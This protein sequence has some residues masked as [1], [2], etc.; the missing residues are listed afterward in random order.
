MTSYEK[1]REL[2]NKLFQ[3]DQADLDFGIYRIM[4][5]KRDEISRFLDERLLPQV[6]EALGEYQATLADTGQAEL[7]EAIE[8]ARGLGV[9]PDEAPRVQEL[10][11]KH[12]EPQDIGK[13]EDEVYSHL[14]SFFRRYYSEG[15]FISQRRYKEGV[16]AIPYEGEEV[17]LHWANHDQYY[18]KSSENFRNYTFRLPDDRMVHFRI[19]EASTGRDNNRAQDDKHRRFMLRD[20]E[21]WGPADDIAPDPE[22][23][24]D[25]GPLALELGDGD[26]DVTDAPT[27]PVGYSGPAITVEDDDLVIRF[28]FLPDPQKRRQKT[29][30]EEIATAV[31]A[32]PA[33]ADWLAGLRT[34]QPTEANADRTLL[35]KHLDQYSKRN[36]FDYFIHKDLGGFLRRELDFYTKNEVMRLDDIENETAPR[37][38]QYLGKVRA[39]RRVAGKL[40]TFL[41]QL[42]DFQKKLW[43]KKKFV[44]ETNYCVT[45]DRVPEEMWP[46]V[47]ANQAQR[48]EWTR[49]FDVSADDERPE[50][51][52]PHLVVDTA[53]FPEAFTDRLLR[54]WDGMEEEAD[55]LLCHGDNFHALTLLRPTW[56]TRVQ[57]VYIDPP[58]NAD[59]TEIVYK[60]AYKHSSWLS[61]IWDR[62]IC[63][64]EML[65]ETGVMCVTIDDYEV[66]GLQYAL[67]RAFGDDNYLATT[68]IRNNP[69]GRATVRGFAVNHE[70]GLYYAKD[71]GKASVG[72]LK[73]TDE[74][75]ARYDE[76]DDSGRQFE[77]ENFRKNSSGSLRPDR[78]KQ[79]FPLYY[80]PAEDS[81]RVP[82][83]EWHAPTNSWLVLE[84]AT[85][86]EVTVL[87]VQSDG[88]ERVWRFGL[89]RSRAEIAEMKVR[90]RA[91]RYEVYKKKYFAFEG[92]L[93]RTWWEDAAYSARD[94]GTRVLRELFGPL[95]SFEFPKAVAAVQDALRV[96]GVGGEGVT[97]DYFAGSGTS[98][99]AVID[100]NREDGGDRKYI[101]VEMGEYFD[102]VLLPRIKKVIYSKDWRDGKPVSREGSSHLLKYIR[103]ESYEDTL[104]NLKLIRTE[105]QQLALDNADEPQASEDYTLSY[106]LDLEAAGSQSLLNL[107]DF[108]RPFEYKLKVATGIAGETRTVNA[109]LVETFNYLIG[110]R[111]KHIDMIRGVRVVAGTSPAGERVLVLWREVDETDSDA[112]DKWFRRQGYNTRDLEYDVIYVNGDNNLENLRR[113]DQTWK[114][115]LIE[116]DFHRLMFDVQDV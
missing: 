16:Y 83:L 68:P 9:D 44:V 27:D 106:M 108:A 103:L 57:C 109:D 101:L 100:L 6:R 14:Y 4:N 18:V 47:F 72:R 45:L 65:A 75:A 54:Q 81:L 10:K 13:L 85:Q 32:A 59:A 111:V 31:L 38:E 76:A 3:F 91:D 17:K 2:L 96:C 15:D 62:V 112:L 80:D 98:A 42:E 82:E 7:Q 5:Q 90:R 73:H 99:H 102:T 66:N 8:Q 34:P 97:L 84:E 36:T 37:V 70:Y 19:V 41:A 26:A 94:N 61:L 87:P 29:I 25:E 104:E 92:S 110:L 33:A 116:A 95:R 39:L 48:E 51:F 50:P 67:Q 89:E 64:R 20:Y 21:R 93:P 77:W 22:P 35:H 30:N 88:V 113:A 63:G 115:R 52:T 58:Y 60:N 56:G 49:L 79:F 105:E 71:A 86:G 23:S 107:E 53:H 40:I 55:G 24:A 12:G 28:V 69:S 1:L 46:E 114:V 74:Q 43:L 11:A 78:P